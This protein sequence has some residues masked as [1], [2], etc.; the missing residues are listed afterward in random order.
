MFSAKGNA[1]VAL[2]RHSAMRRTRTGLDCR[3]VLFRLAPA[4]IRRSI[5]TRMTSP[6]RAHRISALRYRFCS[7]ARILTLRT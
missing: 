1:P 6:F 2:M 7:R 4:G 3:S 5:R